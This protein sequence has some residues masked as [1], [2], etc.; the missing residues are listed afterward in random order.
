MGE[1][2]QAVRRQPE[3]LA[4]H[5]LPERA[6]V[7]LAGATAFGERRRRDARGPAVG[8]GGQ[9][10]ADLLE[11]LANHADPVRERQLRVLERE[12]LGHNFRIEPGAPADRIGRVVVG[13]ELAAGEH[14]VAGGELALR[15]SLHQQDLEAPG[16]A[17]VQEHERRGG[18]GN[19]GG[20]FD[21]HDVV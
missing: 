1:V 12:R 6:V 8:G 13:R 16:G 14:V 2:D 17:V 7:G 15:V 18:H 20:R 11:R 4:L 10:H 5:E 9:E 3:V 19:D 21:G